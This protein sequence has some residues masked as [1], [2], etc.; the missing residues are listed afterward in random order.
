MIKCCGWD[1]SP[2][3]YWG[4]LSGRDSLSVFIGNLTYFLWG[5]RTALVDLTEQTHSRGF[6]SIR[7]AHLHICH[8][9]SGPFPKCCQ[10]YNGVYSLIRWYWGD[11]TNVWKCILW[12]SIAQDLM[13]ALLLSRQS[14]WV[15]P[16]SPLCACVPSSTKQRWKERLSQSRVSVVFN[17]KMHF[18]SMV[19]G[20]II[21]KELIL[22]L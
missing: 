5:P 3:V 12:S 14:T 6:I 19:V 16:Y 22:L 10:R 13:L 15:Q 7:E 18:Q 8:N 4:H 11:Y 17:G 20:M 9:R 1:T 21:K 2:F